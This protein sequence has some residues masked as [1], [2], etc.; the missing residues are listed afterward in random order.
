MMSRHVGVFDAS[1]A[2]FHD[3]TGLIQ[4][5]ENSILAQRDRLDGRVAETKSSTWRNDILARKIV[6]ILGQY[7]SHPQH[8]SMADEAADVLIST[9]RWSVYGFGARLA[10]YLRIVSERHG[11]EDAVR[12][13]LK[14]V[15][16]NE[17]SK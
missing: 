15:E 14:D 5:D 2:F 11:F 1:V 8:E 17:P 10:H 9:N 13:L 3:A 16:N 4:L 12:E 7:V 6:D